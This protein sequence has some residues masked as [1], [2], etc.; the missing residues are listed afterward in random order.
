[1]SCYVKQLLPEHAWRKVWSG[2]ACVLLLEAAPA[3]ACMAQEA[4]DQQR[5]PLRR[6]RPGTAAGADAGPALLLAACTAEQ[7]HF[8]EAGR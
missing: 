7:R 8:D 5:R 6:L 2:P 3:G 4:R 1:M